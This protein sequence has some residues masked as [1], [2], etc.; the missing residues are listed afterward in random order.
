MED[1]LWKQVDGTVS[2]SQAGEGQGVMLP[3]KCCVLM[4]RTMKEVYLYTKLS[5]HMVKY[6]EPD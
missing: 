3:W 1:A 2:A 4:A 5:R 6:M